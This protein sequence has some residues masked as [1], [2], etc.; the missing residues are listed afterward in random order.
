M[1]QPFMSWDVAVVAAGF[2]LRGGM[3]AP[4]VGRFSGGADAEE[5]DLG[6]DEEEP[7]VRP[8]ARRG[9]PGRAGGSSQVK[10]ARGGNA[11]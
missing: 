11:G 2:F 6:D 4:E 10:P 3:A 7:R 1:R 8:E 5:T 9:L